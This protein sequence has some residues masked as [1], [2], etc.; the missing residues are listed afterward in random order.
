M[1]KA[2]RK[3]QDKGAGT[4]ATGAHRARLA[5]DRGL[6]GLAG[7]GVLLT[8]YLLFVHLAGGSALFCSEGAGCDIVQESRW[9]NLFG[10]PVTLWGLGL[11]ALIAV[12]AAT[13]RT[14]ATRW[15]RAAKKRRRKN[16]QNNSRGTGEPTATGK[17]GRL[18]TF[19]YMIWGC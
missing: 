2:R 5:P 17:R 1:A 12:V 16:P 10:L 7:A 15:K 13:G 8:A 9:A 11:Y 19:L 3:A 4:S 6:L 14:P 18:C